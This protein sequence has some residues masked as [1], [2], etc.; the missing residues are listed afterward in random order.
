METKKACNY[1]VLILILRLPAST[2]TL[3]KQEQ[4]TPLTDVNL[5]NCLL[6]ALNILPVFKN[7]RD[8]SRKLMYLIRL[9]RSTLRS[10][11]A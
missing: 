4:F 3:N 7:E 6:S 8:K 11:C 10:L 2:Y 1:S 5:L 9:S